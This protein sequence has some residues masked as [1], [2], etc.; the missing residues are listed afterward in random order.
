M[1]DTT[2]LVHHD[3]TSPHGGF[4]AAIGRDVAEL[5]ARI[6]HLVHELRHDTLTGL[7]NRTYALEEMA[8]AIDAARTEGGSVAVLTIDIDRPRD[9]FLLKRD[10]TN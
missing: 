4:V 2:V 9:N 6:D 3:P 10:S 7:G 5:H 8:G 1:L